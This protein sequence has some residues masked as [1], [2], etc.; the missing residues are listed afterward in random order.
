MVFSLSTITARQPASLNTP[1]FPK[2][3]GLLLLMCCPLLLLAQS[4]TVV[5][6]RVVDAGTGKPLSFITVAFPGSR[7]GTSTNADGAFNLSATG[8]FT[9]VSFSFI[10]YQTVIRNIKPNQINELNIRL[11]STQTQLKEVSVVSAG[12]KKYRNKGNPA[13]E[14]I[15]QVIDHKDQNRMQSADYLQYDQYERIGLSLFNLSQKFV[16][17]G[18]FRKYQFMLD[19]S[20][21][22]NGKKETVLPVFFGEKISR[23]YYRKDPEKSIRIL[24]AERGTNIIKFV[25]TAGVETYLNRLYGNNID[26]YKNNIFV[27]VN[28]FLSP[29][30]DHAP[31]YYKFFITDTVTT[32]TGKLAEIS[33][34]PRAKGD[35]LF[36]GK[37]L[38]TLDG[39]YA[40]EGCELNVNKQI[41]INFL[42]SLSIRL[43]FKPYPDGRYYLTQSNVRADFGILKTKG[44]AIFGER[45]VTFSNYKLNTPLAANFYEGKSEQ[46]AVNAAL[47]D[48]ALWHAQPLDSAMLQQNEV[49]SRINR[50]QNM[51]S[52]KRLTWIA[53]TLTTDYAKIG[54]LQAGPVGSLYSF[55][56]QE[57]SRFQLGART[58]PEFNKNIYLDGFT[59]YGTRDRQFK[60]SLSTMFSLNKVAPYRFPNDYFKLTYSYDVNL[61]GQNFVFNNSQAALKSF[62]TGNTDYWLYNR[63]YSASY[64]KDFESH[65]AYNV[66][67]R[68]WN[69]QAAGAL[70]FNLNDAPGT[71]V[72][73]L[74]T[75]ELTVGLRFAPH[76]QLIQGSRDR[77]TIK[78]VYPILNF[79]LTQGLKGAFGGEYNYTNITA[80][81][82]KRF[83]LSQLGTADVTLLGNYLVG[84]VPFPLLNIAPANQALAY[85]REAYNKMYYL[86]FVSDHYVGLNVTQS[87]N[88]FFLNKVPLVKHLKWREY[89]TG[90][91]LYGGLRDENNPAVS[92]NLF[93]FP[94]GS[95]DSNGTYGLGSTPYIEAGVGIGNIF[96]LLRVDVIKRFNYLDHPGISAYGIK[97]SINPDL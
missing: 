88:G 15:Q 76:E 67:F 58:T 25:D 57:G 26:I 29:I 41:N 3:W 31:N 74:T 71:N 14:L 66:T 19:S 12:K 84:K 17:G 86:E 81:I 53:S 54:P 79:T 70:R 92:N 55:D 87:F 1:W 38:V 89:L 36:E 65:F 69:Q 40:V 45:T 96:K 60:Y 11:S 77:R 47:P 95:K 37:L 51:A 23:H 63:I 30:A 48:T 16:N 34:T 32:A 43:D 90:K 62:Q 73:D 8:A 22:V 75:T 27:M 93:N 59:A 97:F 52:F 78:S 83:F 7:F 42:R 5:K 44:I 68:N 9:R 91:I 6:G 61:P 46:V 49:Y 80:N 33:F 28:E 2:I 56:T 72:R 21:V 64:V 94:T 50:L 4:N 35:L 24:Q 82:Y 13:V 10:G 85:N 20:Q 18:F 39:R